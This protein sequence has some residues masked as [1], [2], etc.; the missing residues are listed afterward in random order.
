MFHGLEYILPSPPSTEPKEAAFA[1]SATNSEPPLSIA[2]II[3]CG[4]G[5]SVA[6]SLEVSILRIE[7]AL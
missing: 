3:A 1:V 2:S 6:E 5:I 7:R 4:Y